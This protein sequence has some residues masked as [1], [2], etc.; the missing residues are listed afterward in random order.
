MD[1][2]DLIASGLVNNLPA[3]IADQVFATF[4]GDDHVAGLAHRFLIPPR[5]AIHSR[6]LCLG[7]TWVVDRLITAAEQAGCHQA[8]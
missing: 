8:N 7:H 4:D 2:Q 1:T 6:E 3:P 5:V